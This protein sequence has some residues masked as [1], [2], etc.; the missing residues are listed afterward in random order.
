[1]SQFGEICQL[2]MVSSC[3]AY[4]IG[5]GSTNVMYEGDLTDN[6]IPDM[7]VHFTYYLVEYKSSSYA[8]SSSERN[9]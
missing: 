3:I 7:Q 6:S 4:H 9:E 8:M 5:T 1:M 2:R